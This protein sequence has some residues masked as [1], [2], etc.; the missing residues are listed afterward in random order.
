MHFRITSMTSLLLAAF[1][2]VVVSSCG[3]GGETDPAA[4]LQSLKQQ[5]ADIDAKIGELEKANPTTAAAAKV[6]AVVLTPVEPE[7]FQHYIDLQ[8][9]VDANQNLPV[10]AKM[11]GSLK[12]V[13][14]Q[15]GDV[16][17][18]GQLLADI[19]DDVIQRGLDELSIQLQTAEDLYN[20]QKGLWD[21]KIGTEFQFIQAKSQKEAIEKR[22]ATTKEQARMSKIYAPISGT[23]DMVMLKAGQAIAPGVPLCQVVNTSD[24]KIVG[25]VPESYVA[26]VQKGEKVKVFFPDLQKEI[27]TVIKYVS[28]T[29]NPINRS[30]TIECNLPGREDFKPNLVAVLKITDYSS[31]NAITVPVHLIQS[32]ESGDYILVAEKSTENSGIVRKAMVKQGS[33]YNGKVEIKTGLKKGDWLITTGFQDVNVEEPISF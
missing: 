21:Q 18:K 25:E 11:P 10:T 13:Y 7:P 6:R 16:V 8:G 27:T 9:R 14:I 32:S 24:L 26:K 1:F 15:N 3:G 28:K 29:I 31:P 2:A 23:V 19:D 12:H 30:F 33:S 17:K 4:E 22:I 20:R 5:K